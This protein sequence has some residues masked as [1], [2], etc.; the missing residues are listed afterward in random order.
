[1]DDDF[2]LEDP[3]EGG[4]DDDD[5]GSS[6][7]GAAAW[8]E[9]DLKRR[10]ENHRHDPTAQAC[11]V[12]RC[13][14]CV[15]LLTNVCAAT[16]TLCSPAAAAKRRRRRQRA[17]KLVSA[18]APVS[19]SNAADP[20]SALAHIQPQHV[21]SR[22]NALRL[23]SESGTDCIVLHSDT[24][25]ELTPVHQSAPVSP[26]GLQSAIKAPGPAQ[27][28]ENRPAQSR[29]QL[30]HN[31]VLDQLTSKRSLFVGPAR[32]PDVTSQVADASS[33]TRSPVLQALPQLS[34]FAARTSR[35]SWSSPDTCSPSPL[36]LRERLHQRGTLRLSTREA[37]YM[38]ADAVEAQHC[39]RSAWDFGVPAPSH[40]PGDGGWRLQDFQPGNQ[41][42]TGLEA[43]HFVDSHD[44]HDIISL[45]T[46]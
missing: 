24:D 32:L 7:G 36:P 37:S 45:V 41:A 19:P 16:S 38:S 15:T 26:V 22:A 14:Q 44:S 35:Q 31:A 2:D 12:D 27:L 17:P 21:C 1:M 42:T 20:S 5:D 33:A 40:K 34:T 23:A 11:A 9:K 8:P 10:G 28:W 29:P 46:P 3:H 43:H 18:S 4:G 6:E 13:E 25:N 39:S 30:T